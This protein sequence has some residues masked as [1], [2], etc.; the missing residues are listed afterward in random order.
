MSNIGRP[1]FMLLNL[2]Q[3]QSYVSRERYK[4]KTFSFIQEP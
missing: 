1:K 4:G 3:M 2:K